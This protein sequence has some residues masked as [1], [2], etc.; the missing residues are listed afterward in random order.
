MIADRIIP[1]LAK[2][3]ETG[4]NRWIACCPGH[5]DKSPSLTIREVDDR[6][7]LHCF[8]GCDIENIV[9]SVGLEVTDLFPESR[10]PHKSISRPFPAVDI[11]KCISRDSVFLM[12]CAKDLREEKKLCDSDYNHLTKVSRRVDAAVKAGGLQ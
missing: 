7:L 6:L 12:L 4:H 8:A 1:L 2:V 10:E 3:K 9:S 5:E 11:L